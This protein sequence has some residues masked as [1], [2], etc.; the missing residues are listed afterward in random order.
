MKYNTWEH[1][2]HANKA[3]CYRY[4]TLL[5]ENKKQKLIDANSFWFQDCK[6]MVDPKAKV[7]LSFPQVEIE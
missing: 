3:T 6:H 4:G 5:A 7:K 2:Y 1:D